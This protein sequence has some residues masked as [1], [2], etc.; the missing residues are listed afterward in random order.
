M[1]QVLVLNVAPGLEERGDEL[2]DHCE[3]MS[4]GLDIRRTVESFRSVLVCIGD[5]TGGLLAALGDAVRQH[6]GLQ[7]HVRV[8]V[9]VR[10]LVQ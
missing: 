1:T 3:L 5:K 8:V 9:A 6:L 7:V 4:I 2:P 10:I